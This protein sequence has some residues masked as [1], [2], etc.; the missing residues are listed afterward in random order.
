MLWNSPVLSTTDVVVEM[1]YLTKKTYHGRFVVLRNISQL[2]KRGK[3]N[4]T[5]EGMIVKIV[6]ILNTKAILMARK[7]FGDLNVTLLNNYFSL[8]DRLCTS[9]IIMV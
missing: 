6:Y 9:L 5:L 1:A 3:V 4:R 2:Q 8:F 7:D